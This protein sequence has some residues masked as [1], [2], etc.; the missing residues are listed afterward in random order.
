MSFR[1]YEKA[2]DIYSSDNDDERN[3]NRYAYVDPRGMY[4]N[5]DETV[6]ESENVLYESDSMTT[7]ARNTTKES[8]N[9]LYTGGGKTVDASMYESVDQHDPNQ[10]EGIYSSPYERVP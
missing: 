2:A 10:D 8:E 7:S 6:K 1:P 4:N 5:S 9:P 3:D